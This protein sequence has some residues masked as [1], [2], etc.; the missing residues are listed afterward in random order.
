M[1]PFLKLNGNYNLLGT[2]DL[3]LNR[4][5]E[6][7]STHSGAVGVGVLSPIGS[8]LSVNSSFVGSRNFYVD[9]NGDN[10]E[11]KVMADPYVLLN[12]R[13]SQ[14][15]HTGIQLFVGVNNILD[16]G[17]SAY[18]SIQPRWFYGGFTGK[19]LPKGKK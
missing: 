11:D 17:D 10:I 4:E 7:R 12:A 1:S 15:V 13:L 5:L 6:G 8:M 19:F 9:T 18:L 2:R 3:V 16:E 14:F